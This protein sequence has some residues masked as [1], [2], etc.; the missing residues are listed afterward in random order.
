M[1]WYE[2][3]IHDMRLCEDKIDM[4]RRLMFAINKPSKGAGI[5]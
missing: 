2:Q 3:I 1:I 5:V 4:Y